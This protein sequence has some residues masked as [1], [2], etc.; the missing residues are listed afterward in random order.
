MDFETLRVLQ[1]ITAEL[2][3]VKRELEDMRAMLTDMYLEI[4]PDPEEYEG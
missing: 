1:G 2:A 4:V 3:A